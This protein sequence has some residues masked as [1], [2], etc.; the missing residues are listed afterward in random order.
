[1]SD[2]RHPLVSFVVPCY[3]HGHFLRECV[4]SILSQTY[5]NVE[6]LVMDDCSPD[7]TPAIAKSIG[8][9]RVVHVRN[10][11]NLGHL[12]NYNKGIHLARGEYVWLL[13]VDD[14]LRRPYVLARF[15][16]ALERFP[17]AAYVFCPAV[18]VHEHAE[19]S[20]FGLHGSK[21]VVFR[22]D[23]FLKRLLVRNCVAT[24][25][26]LVR[27]SSYDRMGAFPLDL[28]YAGDWYQWCRHALFGD[29]AYLAEP[30]VCYRLHALNMTKEYLDRPAGAISDEV[31]V[32][33]RIKETA[34]QMKLNSVAAAALCGIAGDYASRVTQ[35]VAENS[36]F[37]MTLDE[38]ESSLAA[39]CHRASETLR[40]RAAVS[41]ALGDLH[42]HRSDTG[43]AA[44]YYRQAIRQYPGNLPTWIKLAL[45]VMGTPGHAI[46]SAVTRMPARLRLAA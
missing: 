32:R 23:D 17:R 34:E 4:A 15:V 9:R 46:R 24:P 33:W 35:R 7:D 11:R 10:E 27:K 19:G 3:K 13:N 26:V 8:D 20:A 43:A 2:P 37:G 40:I 30:M 45:L 5:S 42:Y 1:M 6:V 25:A 16:E 29:V 21:D 22:G 12:A 14:Y 31:A 38:F 36:R 28:P 18:Q 39:H 41:A 44:R